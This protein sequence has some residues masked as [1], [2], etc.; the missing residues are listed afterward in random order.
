MVLAEDESP[1]PNPAMR[2]AKAAAADWVSLGGGVS[3]PWSVFLGFL[4]TIVYS[5]P[6]GFV[7]DDNRLSYTRLKDRFL[8]AMVS[9]IESS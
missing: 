4:A 7:S 3:S 6:A 9:P 5:V 8:R 2:A 1:P